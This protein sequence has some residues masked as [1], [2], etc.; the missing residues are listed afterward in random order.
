M[1][2]LFHPTTTDAFA[3]T[4]AAVADLETLVTLASSGDEQAWYQLWNQLDPLLSRI[5]SRPRFLGRRGKRIDDQ[6]NI[7]VDV[8]ARMRAANYRRLASYVAVRDARPDLRFETWLRVVAKRVTI[9]YLRAQPEQPLLRFAA[10]ALVP[11]HAWALEMWVK[12]ESYEAIAE[13]TGIATAAEAERV[14]RAAIERLRR[15]F[16]EEDAHE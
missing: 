11:Q 12:R 5:V 14:V 3:G 4:V 7:V 8:M 15:E 13:S 6:R 10:R 9:D 16:R 1:D 2:P